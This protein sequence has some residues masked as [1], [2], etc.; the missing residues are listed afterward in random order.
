MT[1]TTEAAVLDTETSVSPLP[2]PSAHKHTRRP[3]ASLRVW[4][5]HG[6]DCS[7]RSPAGAPTR[8]PRRRRCKR[9]RW[10]R[11]GGTEAEG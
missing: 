4:A 3:P 8:S 9:W 6:G 7:S 10:R 2:S 11:L 1:G 5:H